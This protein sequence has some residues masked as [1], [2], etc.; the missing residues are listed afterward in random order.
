MLHYKKIHQGYTVCFFETKEQKE[1]H[2]R[3][4]WDEMKLLKAIGTYNRNPYNEFVL[5]W[6]WN[7]EEFRMKNECIFR[8]DRMHLVLTEDF[9]YTNSETGNKE[10]FARSFSFVIYKGQS[11]RCLDD[12]CSLELQ[13]FLKDVWNFC[14]E[15]YLNTYEDS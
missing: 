4:D 10:G 14:E 2:V 11:L 13:T 6:D 8:K 9:T 3:D 5:K 12:Y 7:E 1:K 15:E